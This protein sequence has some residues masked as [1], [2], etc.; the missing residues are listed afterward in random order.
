MSYG[1]FAPDEVET[2]AVGPNASSIVLRVE[3]PRGYIAADDFVQRATLLIGPE[4][5]SVTE[6]E[7][8]A[9]L[10]IPIAPATWHNGEVDLA[11][12]LGF[13]EYDVK[14]VCYIDT[15][16]L[17]VNLLPELDE[18]SSPDISIIYRPEPPQ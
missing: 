11:L 9:P 3:L 12:M 10:E 16:R 14:E 13:C 1:W 8:D 7:L 4:A 15:P 18:T 2:L 6:F 5:R 17:S